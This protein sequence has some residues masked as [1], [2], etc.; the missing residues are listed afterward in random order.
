MLSDKPFLIPRIAPHLSLVGVEAGQALIVQSETRRAVLRGAATVQVAQAVDGQRSVAQVLEALAPHI[1]PLEAAYA[2]DWL[3]SAGYVQALETPLPSSPSRPSH[4]SSEEPAFWALL[5]QPQAAQRLQTASVALHCVGD[6]APAP[7]RLLLEQAGLR[8]AASAENPRSPS[9]GASNT[10][11]P[12]ASLHLLVC[13]DYLAPEVAA[14]AQ[15]L[16]G[17][18]LLAKLG[19]V[20]LTVGPLLDA[21]TPG[22]CWHCLAHALRRNRPVQQ[23]VLRHN[24]QAPA[25]PAPGSAAS[26]TLGAGLLA[27]S[28]AQVLAG[29]GRWR[30][31]LLAQELPSMQSAWHPLRQRP[32]CPHC[33]DGA[34]MQRQAEQA[35]RLL[36]T[37]IAFQAEGGYR[38]RSPQQTLAAYRSLISPL[39]GVVNYLHTMPGR[40]GGSRKVYASGYQV[41]PQELAPGNGFDKICAGKGQSD[42]QAQASA[43]CEALERASSVWQGDEP[44]QMASWAQLTQSGQKA[45]AFDL[46]QG[47]SP[48]QYAL[49]EAIN[50]STTDR[51]R[52]VPLP[53][54]PEATL[55]WTPAWHLQN[56]TRHWVPLAYCFSEAPLA[57]GGHYGIYNPNGTAAGNTLEEAIFQGLLELVERDAT[58]LWWYNRLPRP[59]VVL[60]DLQDE[61]VSRLQHEYRAEGWDLRVLDLT[62]DLAIP[63]YAAVAHHPALDRYAI[64]FGCHLQ[65]RLALSRALTELNQLLDA[66]IQAP[67]PWDRSLMPNADFLQPSGRVALAPS[68]GAGQCLKQDIDTCVNQLQAAGLATLVVNKTRPDVGLHVVQVIVPGLRHFWPRFGPGRLYEVPVA[69]GWLPKATEE[70]ALNPAPLFL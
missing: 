13:S 55:A 35:P 27:M 20:Q 38:S 63:V 68:L 36:P 7:L 45:L 67:P 26:L 57:W 15:R 28:V 4:H 11:G 50:A 32:Q 12:N 64:G 59:A 51:R 21:A 58:A 61:F 40:H 62:H 33:G 47:F 69:L 43:L 6:V 29:D 54:N 31:A 46:L 9:A 3:E 39:T 10:G 23:F 49:R 2:L 53:F 19:G 60:E 25:V 24:A 65:A 42:E 8:L 14:L 16:P 1:S 5:G 56:A 17:P 48:R 70:E 22:P 66:R 30:S 44:V 41:C 34:W 37:P 52:Q 18:V